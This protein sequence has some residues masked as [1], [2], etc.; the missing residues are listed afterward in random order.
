[1]V[2]EFSITLYYTA[3]HMKAMINKDLGII[4]SY[5]LEKVCKYNIAVT[6]L[7]LVCAHYYNLVVDHIHTIL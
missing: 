4:A 7:G 5:L 6:G 2:S 1:M 3:L